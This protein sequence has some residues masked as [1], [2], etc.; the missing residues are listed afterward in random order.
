[1]RG[2]WSPISGSTWLPFIGQ[3][4]Q[5]RGLAS[6]AIRD[7]ALP[8]GRFVRYK[9]IPGSNQPTIVYVPGLHSYSHMHGMLSTCLLR[10]CDVNNYPFIT[11][12]HECMGESR[13]GDAKSLLFSHWVED[14]R[15]VVKQLTEGP[16][17]L[18]SLSMGGWLSL[19]GALEIPERIHGMVLYAPALNY[20][21]PYYNHHRSQ[22]TTAIR[23]R[24][25]SGD[26][27]IISN[28]YGDALLKKDFA[29]DS[30]NYELNLKKSV[31][32]KCP[33]RIIH[34]LQDSEV[35]PGQSMDLTNA[36]ES[37][38]VDLIYRKSSVH[39]AVSPPDIELILNTID[40]LFKDNPVY[41]PVA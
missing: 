15:E 31:P 30:L 4:P 2:R 39:Q 33:I 40:R 8:N 13:D 38:D 21:Y 14:V 5:P 19:V 20:V 6:Q 27:H 1:M 34:G 9:Q 7:L 12:D 41:K 3:N 24:L 17:V 10:Y 25:D 26:I 35:K 11:Y 37:Q 36:L 23:E 28:S 29:E 22:L 18:V 32:L 16:V